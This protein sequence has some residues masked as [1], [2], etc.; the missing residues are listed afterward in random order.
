ME[1]FT[2]ALNDVK[3]AGGEAGDALLSFAGGNGGSLAD[4]TKEEKDQFVSDLDNKDSDLRQQIKD[5]Y[6]E[7]GYTT[8]QGMI[9][10]LNKA[11]DTYDKEAETIGDDLSYTAKNAFDKIKDNLDDATLSGQESVADAF[12]SV[13]EGGGTVAVGQLSTILDNL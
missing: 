8:E 4:L 6:D 11:A 3:T 1:E 9:D 5:H 2:A 12:E 7:F 13:L 10:A